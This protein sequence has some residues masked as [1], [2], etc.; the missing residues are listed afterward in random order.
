MN[1]H[2][3]K[4]QN[5][6]V[7]IKVDSLGPDS[8]LLHKILGRSTALPFTAHDFL[9]PS[10]ICESAAPIDGHPTVPASPISWSLHTT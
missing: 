8:L 1:S 10:D 2:L 5:P 3:S 9:L 7:Q 6:A 4:T